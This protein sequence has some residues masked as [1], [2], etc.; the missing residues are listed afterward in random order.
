MSRKIPKQE[1]EKTLSFR[2]SRWLNGENDTFVG[3]VEMQPQE[4][5]HEDDSVVMNRK[6]ERKQRMERIY[7]LE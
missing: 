3:K 7:D 4:E 6:K 2:L 5:P 1:Y